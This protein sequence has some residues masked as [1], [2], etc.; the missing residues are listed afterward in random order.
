LKRVRAPL[1]LG[2]WSQGSATRGLGTEALEDGYRS[3][4]RRSYSELVFAQHAPGFPRRRDEELDELLR[5]AGNYQSPSEL[6]DAP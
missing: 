1:L 2:L 4:L 3:P 6:V 5:E